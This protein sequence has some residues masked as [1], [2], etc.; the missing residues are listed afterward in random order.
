[1]PLEF[2]TLTEDDI[3]EAFKS[4][5]R[6]FLGSEGGSFGARRVTLRQEKV[7]PSDQDFT[8]RFDSSHGFRL[9]LFGLQFK[10]WHSNGWRLA[11]EQ[12]ERLRTYRHVIAYCLAHPG[13]LA[14]NNALHGFCFINPGRVAKKASQ[15]ALFRPGEWLTAEFA[16]NF[17]RDVQRRLDFTLTLH[18]HVQRHGVAVDTTSIGEIGK[19]RGLLR[20]AQTSVREALSERGLATAV[21]ASAEWGQTIVG[22]VDAEST[23]FVPHLSWGDFFDAAKVGST[24]VTVPGDPTNPPRPEDPAP[25]ENFMR[26]A[27]LGLTITC[28]GSRGS[29]WARSQIDAHVEHWLR[30]VLEPP[31][32]VIA[33]ESFTRSMEFFAYAG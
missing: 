32:V 28:G 9:H 4:G 5:L 21:R 17:V 22:A 1:M 30:T 25:D 24:V 27:G 29:V 31:A 19:L 2:Q 26:A 15:L 7:F 23:H 14:T 10:K 12:V 33:Y 18:E 6:A 16:D 20:S 11:E 13:E 8:I 3:V